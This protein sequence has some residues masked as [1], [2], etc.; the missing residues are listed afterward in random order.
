M[1]GGDRVLL[2]SAGN[3]VWGLARMVV[4]KSLAA[5]LGSM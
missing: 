1:P 5:Q 2:K 4:V 3:L